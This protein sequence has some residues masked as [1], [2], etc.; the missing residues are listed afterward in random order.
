MIRIP[1]KSAP[2]ESRLHIRVDPKVKA[3]F[4]KACHR[5][6]AV[7]AEVIRTLMVQFTQRKT[8]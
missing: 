2:K 6:N 7:P 4:Y 3:A 1:L 5:Y 8:K